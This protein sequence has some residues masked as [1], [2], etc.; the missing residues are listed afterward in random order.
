MAP[1][2]TATAATLPAELVLSDPSGDQGSSLTIVRAGGFWVAE[3]VEIALRDRTTLAKLRTLT[4]V[5]ANASGGFTNLKVEVPDLR[6]GCDCDVTATGESSDFQ[7][8]KPFQV[9]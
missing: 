4:K 6:G 5:K 3:I 9:R 2:T 7:L 8:K 1:S